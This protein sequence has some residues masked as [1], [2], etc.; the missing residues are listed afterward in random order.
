MKKKILL[1]LAFA[2]AGVFMLYNCS[3]DNAS[4]SVANIT[5]AVTFDAQ[6]AAN[7]AIIAISSE[8]NAAKV[9]AK[10][11]ADVDGKY[12]IVGIKDGTYYL[13][14]KY[15]TNNQNNTK[16]AYDI[17]F[18]TASEVTVTVSG[19]DL[20]QDLALV[21]N[22]SSGTDVVE[23]SSVSPAPAGKYLLDATHSFIGFE[24]PYDSLNAS[25]GGH[26]AKF[27]LNTFKFDQANPAN[28]TIDAWVDITS[29]ETGSATKVDT[30]NKKAVGGRDGLNGC[31]SHTF[32]VQYAP[33][34]TFFKGYYRPTAVV[35]T[36]GKATFV[37]TSVAAYG[38]GY[39]AVGA[40]NFHG[41]SKD[42]S[43][44]FH[45]IKGYTATKKDSKTGLDVTTQYSSFS[46][47]FKMNALFDFKIV[48]GHVKGNP[49]NV[50]TNLEFAKIVQ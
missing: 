3:K 50:T 13:S 1:L 46:G 42:V 26:F 21:S 12:S 34:D 7:G 23:F 5:G 4:T 24:F 25:F 15:N 19:A 38:D 18:T 47:F 14:A 43:L 28:S 49:V 27:G 17:V 35:G 30:I 20:V 2:F 44:Y 6:K 41:F 16:S 36:T 29:T 22:A 9:L 11:V 48:S 45:Y 33:A 10:V 40:L 31:I 32:G 37:S 39:V 8:P